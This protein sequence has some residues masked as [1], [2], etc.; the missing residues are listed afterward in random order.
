MTASHPLKGEAVT[1]AGIERRQSL[2]YVSSRRVAVMVAIVAGMMACLTIALHAP[3]QVSMDTSVQLFEALTGQSISF[4]PPFM[5][6]L[7]HWLGG[8][9]VATSLLVMINTVLLYGSFALVAVSIALMREVR[10]LGPLPT[11]RAALALLVILNPMVFL[12]AGIV[13]KDVL[14]ASLLTSGCAFTIAASAGG[15]FRR[16]ACA[17]VALV[18]LAGALITRQQGVFMVPLV[19]LAVIAALWRG[20]LRQG[21]V[22]ALV[23]FGAFMTVESLLS[24]AVDKAI[25]PPAYVA[26]SV[27]LRS[28]MTFDLAGMVSQSSRSAEEYVLPITPEQLNAVRSAYTPERVDTL[29]HTPFIDEWL[30]GLSNDEVRQAWWAMLK[31]NPSAYLKHRL[32]AYSKLMGLDGIEGTLPIHIGVEGNA[33]YLAQ[34]G[35][36]QGR[37]QRTQLIYDIARGFFATVLYRHVFWFSLLAVVV[38]VGAVACLQR[39]LLVIGGLIALA[40]SLLYA[41]YLPTAIAA[42]FRYLFGGIP[43]VML[44]ALVVLLGGARKRI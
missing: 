3:G 19:I 30:S 39:R 14:F 40:A 22:L 12:Y 6:A 1:L 42:D 37:N 44:L 10:G 36:E 20:Q 27:G 38:V 13:W 43:L 35:M 11:W 4:N 29:S 41:S 33:D 7:L 31:Q 34:V 23:V 28:L 17:L 2:A 24:R 32:A 8:G 18:L 21:I 9:S 26:S 15:A 5:S 25:K 16:Y